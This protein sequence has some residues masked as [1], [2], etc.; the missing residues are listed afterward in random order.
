MADKYEIVWACRHCHKK[1]EEVHPGVEES[2]NIRIGIILLIWATNASCPGCSIP[3]VK[4]Y[5]IIRAMEHGKWVE[6]SEEVLKVVVWDAFMKGYRL[7]ICNDV[8]GELGQSVG[9]SSI[10]QHGFSEDGGTDEK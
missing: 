1:A 3:E 10:T 6:W 9:L 7:V 5:P 8:A 2:A 4:L